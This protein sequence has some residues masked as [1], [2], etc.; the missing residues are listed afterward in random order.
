MISGKVKDK[1]VAAIV[2][3]NN[4]VLAVSLVSLNNGQVISPGGGNV[5]SAGG[6]N[7]ISPGGGNVISPGGGNMTFNNNTAGLTIGAGY[8][9]QSTGVKRVIKTAG[10]GTIAIK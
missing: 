3:N 2:D 8:S 5:I 4:N 1:D 10:K 9:T 6:D 7:V